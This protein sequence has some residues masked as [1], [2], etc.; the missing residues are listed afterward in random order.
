[1]Y[2]SALGLREPSLEQEPL[3]GL[4]PQPPARP[5]SVLSENSA[6]RWRHGERLG[7]VIEEACRR[8]AERVAVS[9]ESADISYRELDARA[10]Q[11]AR[12][13]RA[14]GV[15]PG[16][17]VAVLLDRGIEAYVAL[18]AILKA[19]AA[20]VPLDANHPSDR[21]R[22]IVSDAGATL[23]VTH[24]R[25]ADRVADCGVPTLVLD[26]TRAEAAT[27]DRS[28]LVGGDRGDGQ[29]HA[30]LRPVHVRH[31]R[32]PEGRRGRPSEHLQFR[33]R[34]RRALRFRARR[35]GLPGHVARLR[36]LDRGDLGAAGR[37]GDAR[38]EHRRDK[39]V[40][41]GTR[42]LPRVSRRHV[43]LLRADAARLDRARAAE[44]AHPADRG[45]GLPAGAGQALEPAGPLPPQQLRAD[46][47]DGH[48]DARGDDARQA[49]DDRRAAA[50]LFGRHSRRQGQCRAGPRRGRRNRHRRNRRRG[51]LSQP[52]P[53]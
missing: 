25:L 35:S 3:A 39:P 27:L 38:P 31:D 2:N 10:N 19:G 46:R 51:G 42:R 37:G 29:Q 7:D 6:L 4:R 8:Y 34:G 47:N 1:M 48:R 32:Q 26:G 49:G 12:L 52:A 11:M 23:A 22:F 18:L 44:A 43:L 13:F 50:D 9:V 17:R 40:R 21:I 24:L 14:R 41:R 28:P 5:P 30:L 36:L 45:R 20:Y 53:N 33:A 16:D 15:T